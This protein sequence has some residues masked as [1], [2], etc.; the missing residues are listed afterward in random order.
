MMADPLVVLVNRFAKYSMVAEM[1]EEA[2]NAKLDVITK[3]HT[4]EPPPN[5]VL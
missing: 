1:Y 3:L 2:I 4:T 5:F